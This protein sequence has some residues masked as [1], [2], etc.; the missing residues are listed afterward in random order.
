[1]LSAVGMQKFT[2][3]RRP[4]DLFQANDPFIISFTLRD[5]YLSGSVMWQRKEMRERKKKSAT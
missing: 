3:E 5:W 4:V 1:M 2:F